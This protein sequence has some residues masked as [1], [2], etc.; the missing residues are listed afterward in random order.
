M[1]V[2]N[3]SRHESD[4]HYFDYQAEI[5]ARHLI[6]LFHKLNVPTD[7]IL[8]VGCGK[9]G[10]AIALAQALET[11]VLGID[12]NQSHIEFARESARRSSVD[13]RFEVVNLGTD[14]L[15]EDR[16]RLLL[17]RDVIEHLPSPRQALSALHRILDVD[18]LLYVTFPPWHGPYAGHQHN[19][20]SAA[21]FMPYF[22]AIAPNFFLALIE[23]W[24]PERTD[25]LADERQ[26]FQNRLTRRQFEQ[27]ARETGWTVQYRQT[28]LFRPA[29]IRMGL[30][31]VPNGII[32][33]LPVLGEVLT[34]ACEYLLR[35]T[36]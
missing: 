6:P 33:R 15:P 30:P 34:T 1:R 36:K 12:I 20:K 10:C 18:G 5:A 23:R 13:A 17:L 24:E 32:G 4:K 28:Y 29:F 35:P 22:H 9:G 19:A 16:Y 27:I 25:W 21:K 3:R 2:L 7:R 8:D 14:N 11:T 26:I 31:T